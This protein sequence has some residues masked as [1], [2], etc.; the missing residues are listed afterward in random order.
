MAWSQSVFS[1]NVAEVGYS[2]DGELLVTFTNGRQY[3]YEGVPEETA[4]EMSKTASVGQ[5]LNSEIKGKYNY[6]RLS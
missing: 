1:S 5:Y 3:A 4:L 6:R 2:D